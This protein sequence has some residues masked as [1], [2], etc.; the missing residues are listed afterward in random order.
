MNRLCQHLTDDGGIKKSG[1]YTAER[2]V[3]PYI[4]GGSQSLLL[5]FDKQTTAISPSWIYLSAPAAFHLDVGVLFYLE[6][7]R[8]LIERSVL[9]L[10]NH[11]NH[12]I[13]VKLDKVQVVELLLIVVYPYLVRVFKHVRDALHE[14]NTSLLVFLCGVAFE[15]LLR[16]LHLSAFVVIHHL[17]RIP[18]LVRIPG[19]HRCFFGRC[20]RFLSKGLPPVV[21]L[22]Q[23]TQ[24]GGG[25]MGERAVFMR[26]LGKHL[27]R[28]SPV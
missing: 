23:V 1:L 12:L 27:S 22:W 3:N 11:V 18:P 2:D 21:I 24:E 16:K 8:D 19:K 17:M 5:L 4:K 9:N 26:V 13:L 7:C 20:R 14:R 6:P 10:A 28:F 25:V 15:H